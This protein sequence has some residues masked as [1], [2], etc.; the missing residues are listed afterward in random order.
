MAAAAAAMGK[1]VTSLDALKTAAALP[2]EMEALN[3]L[4]KAQADVKKRE[5]Q[6]QQ[7]GSGSGSN[8]TQLRPVGAVRQ[9]AAEGAA[10]QL[11]DQVERRDSS[12]DPNQSALDKIKDLA[13]RQDE[14]LKRQQEL[15]RKRAQMTRRGAEA[16]AREADARA[17][18]AAAAG[19][20]A[21]AADERGSSP[22]SHGAAEAAA[23]PSPG[24]R[25]SP[26]SRAQQGQPGTAGSAGTVRASRGSRGQRA[27]AAATRASGCATSPRRCATPPANCGVRIP[28]RR[29]ARGNRALEKLRELERQLEAA[30]PDE[31]RRA[32][33]EMQLEARQLADAQRQI[34]SELG[35][36]GQGE[37]GKDAVRR[38]AGEQ[39][40]LAERARKLQESL[41]QQAGFAGLGRVR[42]VL[43]C[44]GSQAPV[45]EVAPSAQAQAARR[46]RRRRSSVSGC[47]R[48]H[49]ADGRRDAAGGRGCARRPRQHRAAV[50]RDDRRAAGRAR[51][52][53]SRARST[54]WPTSSRRRTGAQDGESQKLSDQLRARAGAARK[55]ERDRRES[56]RAMNR[57]G[58][59]RGRPERAGRTQAGSR[60]SEAAQKSAGRKSGRGRRRQQGGGGGTGADLDKLR[61][62]VS[63]SAAAD[64]GARRSAAPRRSELRA[65]RRRRLHLRGADAASACRRPAPKLQAGLREVGRAAPPGDAGARQRRDV[66]VEE[67]AGETGEGSA[68]RRRRRQG[69]GRNTRSRSTATSR[70][71]PGR[72]NRK[73]STDAFRLSAALV[74]GGRARGG[75]RRRRV[76]SS[77]GV[78]SSPLTRAQRGVL[79]GTARARARGARAVSVPSDRRPA[80]GRIARRDRAGARR[81]VAQH[82][83][84]RRGRPDAP[85]PRDALLKNEL[86][87]PLSTAL[88]DRDLRASATALA[89]ATIEA[90]AA[91]ARRTD[92]RR[93]ARGGARAVSRPARRRHRRAVGRRRHR[94]GRSSGRERQDRRVGRDG[95]GPPVFAVGIGSPDGPRDREVLGITAGDPRLDH[96]TVD[97]HVTAVSTGFGRAP[98]TLR[99]LAQR[100][101]A[102]HAPRRA[103]RPTARRSTR[104]SPCRPIR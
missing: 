98:F 3:R 25:A 67:A 31:R 42:K 22:A 28:G 85:R 51:S 5:V 24:S 55:A 1:A 17:V 45:P 19:R 32:L 35:K 81:R 12:E 76:C 21:R 94:G 103:D 96:A 91:D 68:R 33:G 30:R 62:A 9:G 86:G 88:H 38:L 52:R 77:I 65:R 56:A 87:L 41:K 79:V 27:A 100:P 29:A 82:A 90:L 6:R 63:A 95:G 102:R 40:R 59:R 83:A 74:A 73:Q 11:R 26:V 2:P 93:R 71:S 46:R 34:A 49:A 18:R 58:Q 60:Q 36:A 43:G 57:P 23:G 54:R 61:E 50:R 89:P 15:A 14:L 64:Q 104:C 10:D 69:A 92:L 39:E 97:L 4:L 70:R 8:R 84:C 37:A 101:A 80:A 44:E 99:V 7:A 72:R 75:D 78:R 16:R 20:G 13:R 53:S 66:A 48:A 47:R